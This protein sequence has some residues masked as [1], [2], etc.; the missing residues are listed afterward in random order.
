MVRAERGLRRWER[1]VMSLLWDSHC[2]VCSADC[3]G[4]DSFNIQKYN[5]LR[6]KEI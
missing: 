6:N 3:G 1:A 2:A 4:G 5:A